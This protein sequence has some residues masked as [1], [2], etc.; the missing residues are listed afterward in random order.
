[1][2]AI[3]LKY[4]LWTELFTLD[5]PYLTHMLNNKYSN[6]GGTQRTQELSHP[7]PRGKWMSFQHTRPNQVQC[8]QSCRLAWLRQKGKHSL[9]IDIPLPLGKC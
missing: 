7:N 3:K 1:M 2:A 5:L 6:N 9:I 4:K 8:F